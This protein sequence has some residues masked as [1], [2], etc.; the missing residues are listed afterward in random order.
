VEAR[1]LSLFGEKS[2]NGPREDK[3]PV[4]NCFVWKSEE[5]KGFTWKNRFNLKT[6]FVKFSNDSQWLSLR[7]YHSIF[8]TEDSL[9]P[10]I[11]GINNK[12]PNAGSKFPPYLLTV[13]V[14][15]IEK[16][17]YATFSIAR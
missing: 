15:F 3:H 12:L 2:I 14:L 13:Y 8:C 7:H 1:L 6:S 5:K 17:Y 16:I 10:N 11:L 4:K 9:W